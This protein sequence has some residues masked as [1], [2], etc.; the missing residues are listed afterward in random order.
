[1]SIFRRASKPSYTVI[2]QRNTWR[3]VTTET[4]REFWRE[5]IVLVHADGLHH[6]YLLRDES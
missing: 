3:A 6:L 2:E 4:G 1:M 5:T